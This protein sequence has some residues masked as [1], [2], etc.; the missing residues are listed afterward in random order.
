MKKNRILILLACLTL[1]ITGCG[2]DGNST[3]NNAI[4][5]DIDIY[6]SDDVDVNGNKIDKND[7]SIIIKDENTQSTEN[8]QENEQPEKE[9]NLLAVHFLDVG[10]AD[11]TLIQINNKEYILIDGGNN[12]D[13]EDIVSYLEA[14][15]VKSLD[16]IIATHPHEDHIGGLDDVLNKFPVDKVYMP[17]I[18]EEVLPT[19]VTY[20]E[21]LDAVYYSEAL[22]YPAE[23]GTVIYDANDI[24]LEI[25]SPTYIYSDDLNDYS[26]IVKLS[27]NNNSFIITADSSTAITEEILYEYYDTKFLDCDVLKVGHHGSYTSTNDAWL[28]TLTP[29][30]AV[31]HAGKN[32]QYG[33]PHAEVLDMLNNRNIKTYQTMNDGTV[34]F[35]SD[36]NNIEIH[37][38]MTGDAVMGTKDWSKEMI[39]TLE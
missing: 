21:F 9:E 34:I 22:V 29:Q 5:S 23:Q 18:P 24:K 8:T 6:I 32:N 25:I 38:K 36:G 33:H 13:G 12:E 7:S 1:L 26:I 19:T 3:M 31:I 17:E 16:S 14:Y 35:T 4:S 27:Y 37:T 2:N 20:E 10:Q 39:K 15:N 11:S 30:Y 28:D